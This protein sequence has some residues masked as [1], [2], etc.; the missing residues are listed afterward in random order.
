MLIEPAAQLLFQANSR[1]AVA[2]QRQ[3]AQR[4]P[5]SRAVLAGML[6]EIV[7]TASYADL[8]PA[9]LKREQTKGCCRNVCGEVFA[10]EA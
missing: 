7:E 4:K 8:S 9:I 10:G 2:S 3:D 6:L 5:A 1:A